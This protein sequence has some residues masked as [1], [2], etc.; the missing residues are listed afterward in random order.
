MKY[1]IEKVSSNEMT[2]KYIAKEL[3]HFTKKYE[4]LCTILAERVLLGGPDI[5]SSR[6]G[7]ITFGSKYREDIS[8][9]AMIEVNKVCFSDIPKGQTDIHK[10][11]YGNFGISFDKDFIAKKGGIPVHYIPRGAVI[12]P[13]LVNGGE[14]MES[15][16]NRMTKELYGHFE[17]LI[18]EYWDNEEKREKYQRLH[19]F[20]EENIKTYFKFF[21]HTLLDEDPDNYYFEREWCVVGSVKFEMSD[22]RSVLLPQ[23]YESK[24]RQRFP[25]YKGPISFT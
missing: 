14:T 10:A 13:M 5:E 6:K 7:G 4:T 15:F 3:T 8:K 17:S 25:E 9:N 21:D 23:E 2:Q 11:K 19:R 16:F 18:D 1:K 20:I 12:N 24:F 22:I